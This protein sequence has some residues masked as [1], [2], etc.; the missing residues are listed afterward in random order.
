MLNSAFLLSSLQTYLQQRS[1]EVETLKVQPMLGAMIDWFRSVPVHGI[2]HRSPA[3]SLVYRYGAWSEGCAT[4]FKFSLLRRVLE[5]A[6]SGT[7][8]EWLAGITLVFDPSR[9]TDLAPFATQSTDWSSLEAFLHAIESTVAFKLS[10][11]R[12]PMG[13]IL[14]SGGMR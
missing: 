11:E 7:D 3:D 4:G 13:V 9:Y 5:R 2:P 10:A 14:E 1:I 8:T 12:A 6:D